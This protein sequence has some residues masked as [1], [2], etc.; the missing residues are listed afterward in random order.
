MVNL[1]VLVLSFVRLTTKNT[2][3]VL[4]L[5]MYYGVS[6]CLV[7]FAS[8][9]SVVTL[10]IYHRGV[11]GAAVP[12]ILRKITLEKLAPLIFMTFENS[13]FRNQQVPSD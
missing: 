13:R 4:F 11:R 7:T 6:I 8:A 1:N 2:V 5:G 3:F 10:N 12:R 9:L